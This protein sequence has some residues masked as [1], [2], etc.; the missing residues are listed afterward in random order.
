M[1][2]PITYLQTSFTSANICISAINKVC[3]FSGMQEDGGKGVK[4]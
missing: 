4:H 2:L 1:Y 3:S